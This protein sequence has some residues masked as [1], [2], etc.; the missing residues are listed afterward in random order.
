MSHPLCRLGVLSRLA[1]A[2]GAAPSP[3]TE[4]SKTA[5][6]GT[7]PFHNTSIFRNTLFSTVEHS[8]S[9]P[10]LKG[11]PSVQTETA[12]Q[13]RHEGDVFRINMNYGAHTTSR[14]KPV[15]GHGRVREEEPEEGRGKNEKG[16]M[17]KETNVGKG[18]AVTTL[19]C[20][21]K[22]PGKAANANVLILLYYTLLAMKDQ[23]GT[24]GIAS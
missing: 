23:G 9:L 1:L 11:L 10:T 2:T 5:L 19:L 24:R 15:I 12:L 7:S 3:H 8:I 16:V 6:V 18:P 14:R 22:H 17:S 13:C 20:R 21:R 4:P